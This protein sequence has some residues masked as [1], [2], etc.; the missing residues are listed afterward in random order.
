MFKLGQVVMTAGVSN[1]VNP[2]VVMACIRRHSRGDW[3]NLDE[4]DK[5]L[6]DASVKYR[7]KHGEL[8]ERLM[9]SYEFDTF[10][11]WVITEYDESVTTV[12]FP[13]EY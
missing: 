9:S 12:L 2:L 1:E 7:E 3:G 5:K 6:N 8:R 4:H 11:L 13:E 10:K